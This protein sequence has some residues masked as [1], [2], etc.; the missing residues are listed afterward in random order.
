M[1]ASPCCIWRK[2][3]VTS[4]AG[5]LQI[6]SRVL[7]KDLCG[8]VDEG[9]CASLG[10]CPMATQLANAIRGPFRFVAAPENF[11]LRA[12]DAKL[13]NSVDGCSDS[14]KKK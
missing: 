10:T 4:G 6:V 12:F 7:I 3:V 2:R 1:T 5:V 11:D 14:F 9:L 8:V 13:L